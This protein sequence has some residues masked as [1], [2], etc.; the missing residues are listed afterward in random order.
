[1]PNHAGEQFNPMSVGRFPLLAA[2]S[3]AFFSVK[4]KA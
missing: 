1:M 4:G 2:P 3:P